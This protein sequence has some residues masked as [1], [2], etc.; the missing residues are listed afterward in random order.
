MT[1]WKAEFHRW[2]ERER[3]QAYYMPRKP[4]DW[5]IA[6][7][8]SLVAHEQVSAPEFQARWLAAVEQAAR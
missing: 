1:R 3:L 8:A 4:E 2:A 7:A 6:K 5:R